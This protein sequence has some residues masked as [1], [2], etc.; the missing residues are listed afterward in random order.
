[1][2]VHSFLVLVCVVAAD[3]VVAVVIDNIRLFTSVSG[4]YQR[5]A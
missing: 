4:L 3:R 1:M 2:S 5:R